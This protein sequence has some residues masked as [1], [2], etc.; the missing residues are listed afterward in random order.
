MAVQS[1]IMINLLLVVLT[2]GL[3]EEPP[4]SQPGCKDQCGNVTVPYPFGIGHSCYIDD[5][6]EIVCNGTGAFLKKINVKVLGI[7][8]TR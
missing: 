4:I 2:N 3:A 7:N 1:V 5:W 6:F 8:I